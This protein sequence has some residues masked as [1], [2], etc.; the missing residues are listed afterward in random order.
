MENKNAPTTTY[1]PVSLLQRIQ[2]AAVA[3]DRSLAAEI[4]NTLARA[5]SDAP[6]LELR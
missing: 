2:K 5:Y 4:R 1:L 6:K 3:Q